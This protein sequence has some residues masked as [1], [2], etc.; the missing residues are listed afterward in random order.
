V[1]GVIA[2]QL[3]AAGDA[4]YGRLRRQAIVTV[5]AAAVD[6]NRAPLA[7]Q[8]GDGSRGGAAFAQNVADAQ[9]QLIS[10]R[11]VVDVGGVEAGK[12]VVAGAGTVIAKIPLIFRR[13]RRT[14]AKIGASAVLV[15]NGARL[16]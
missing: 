3:L 14:G 7:G 5:V 12:N 6:V 1:R 16:N 4:A 2:D 13:D 11:R 15:G 8:H 9:H 10:S